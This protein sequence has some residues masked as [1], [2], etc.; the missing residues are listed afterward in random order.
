MLAAHA[1]VDTARAHV[2]EALS[3][4]R[5]LTGQPDIPLPVAESIGDASVDSHPRIV[6][7]RTAL[8]RA[9]QSLTVINASRSDPPV[10]GVLMRREQDNATTGASRTVGMSVQI[11][12]GTRARNRPL[13]T[14]AQTHIEVAIAELSQAET[15][16]L[17]E[18]ELARS[19]LTVAHETMV[20]LASRKALTHEHARLIR[21][22]FRLGEHGLADVLRA[23]ALAHEA[24]ASE[25]QQRVALGLAHARLNQAL[26][27]LP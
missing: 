19:Q 14:T 17:T 7:A 11:P 3:R 18:I 15:G 27:I 8:Q 13:E 5:T 6:A 22:A 23:Q 10:L 20:T 26:G 16:I 24:E 9:K 25:R 2:N 1:A 12:I 21:K 4:Y